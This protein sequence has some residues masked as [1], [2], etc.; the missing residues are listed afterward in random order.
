MTK[1]EVIVAVIVYALVMGIFL[2]I[3]W[4]RQVY[5]WGS[6]TVMNNCDIMDLT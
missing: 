4:L 5:R 1:R 2:L 6:I 3:T